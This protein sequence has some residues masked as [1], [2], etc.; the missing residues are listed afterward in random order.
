MR[1]INAFICSKRIALLILL[2][3]STG[4][5]V[6]AQTLAGWEPTLDT[7]L[8]PR[9]TVWIT[10]SNG[11]DEKTRVIGVAD[12]VL[13]VT[14]GENVRRLST[15]DVMKVRVRRS[16]SLLRRADRRWRCAGLGAVPLHPN[17]TVGEL[18]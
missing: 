2:S 13:T 17:G 3:A 4:V 10:D 14:R 6:S 12:G 16:D 7:L 18:S 5:P 15:A 8:A 9:M 11:P 1:A